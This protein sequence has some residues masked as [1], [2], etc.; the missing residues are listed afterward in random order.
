VL[1]GLQPGSEG[2]CAEGGIIPVLN[3]LE[4]WRAWRA[5]AKR[6]RRTLPAVLQFDTGMS[7]LGVSPEELGTLAVELA[8][9]GNIEVGFIIS[10][11][12]SSDELDC[13]QND[14]QL[15]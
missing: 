11:L 10:H 14:D 12:A 8:G 6:L 1:N 9:E 2:P 4:Q 5:T 3:S 15:A 13:N 7:R